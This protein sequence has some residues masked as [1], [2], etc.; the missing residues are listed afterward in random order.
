MM[1]GKEIQ[2]RTS[3]VTI[4]D[5]LH[6]SLRKVDEGV[7]A[8]TGIVASEKHERI[9]AASH[10]VQGVLRG[11]FLKIFKNEWDKFKEKGS[12]EEDYDFTE[13]STSCLLELLQFLDGDMPDEKR[14]ILLKK[15]FLVAAT[16][17]ITDRNSHLPLQYMQI[18]R[19]LSAGEILVLNATFRITEDK[20]EFGNSAQRWLEVM[21][22]ESNLKYTALVE[23]Y[24]NRLMEKH[25][26]T[27]RKYADRRGISMGRHY[28]LTDLAYEICRYIEQYDELDSTR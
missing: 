26:L 5:L 6:W 10:V 14:F 4:S 16:E 2:P 18:C 7:K 23:I 9:C 8:V 13:Q 27:E 11:K 1:K 15:I 12:I 25:L 28:R 19:T 20:K 22:E 3:Q 21:A 24:E 17:K